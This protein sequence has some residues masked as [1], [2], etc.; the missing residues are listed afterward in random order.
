MDI[1]I[2]S[3]THPP[4]GNIG[5]NNVT[6][7]ISKAIVHIVKI[8][9]SDGL[10]IIGDGERSIIGGYA[11]FYIRNKENIESSETIEVSTSRGESKIIKIEVKKE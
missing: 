2:P 7:P 4:E 9:V 10:S 8:K 11:S 3:K 5:S 6:I 1:I